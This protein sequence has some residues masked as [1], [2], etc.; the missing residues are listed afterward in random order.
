M[1]ERSRGTIKMTERQRRVDACTAKVVARGVNI[2]AIRDRS[3]AQHYMEYHHIPTEVIARVLDN[4]ASRRMP[5]TEQLLSEAITPSAAPA[6]CRP[7]ERPSHGEDTME[8]L[9]ALPP[10]AATLGVSFDGRTYHY[11][12]YSY[13]RLP[14][15]LDYARRD[16]AKPGFRADATPRTWS[17][18][19]G[20]TP[21]ER[22]Q[23][24]R[25]GIVYVNGQYCYGPYRYDT[26]DAAM[27]YAQRAPGL[28]W[29]GG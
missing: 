17:P 14:D 28:A 26:L 2:L 24:A 16:R 12:E 9:P 19:A 6:D 5:S 10:E 20:P 15:A 3:V 25:H 7:A 8:P 18:W 27:A 22:S 11:R 23:M 1:Q 4:P 21:D 29:P 13:D